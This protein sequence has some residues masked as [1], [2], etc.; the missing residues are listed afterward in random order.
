M[1]LPASD[2]PSNLTS[3]TKC[4]SNFYSSSKLKILIFRDVEALR[5]CLYLFPFSHKVVT[6]KVSGSGDDRIQH[7]LWSICIEMAAAYFK[8]GLKLD[9][10]SIENGLEVQICSV[11]CLFCSGSHHSNRGGLKLDGKSIENGLEGQ[12]CSIGRLFWGWLPSP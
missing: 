11:K 9:E 1:G 6:Q 7:F 5:L 3:K 12:K 4:G 2:L 10:K 8:S